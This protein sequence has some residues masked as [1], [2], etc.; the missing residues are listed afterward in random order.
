MSKVL[1]LRI[2]Q[3]VEP[4]QDHTLFDK[5]EDKD[6][7]PVV[8]FPPGTIR[9][10]FRS[11]ELGTGSEEWALPADPTLINVPLYGEQVLVYSAIDGQA[12]SLFQ[13]RYYY[14]C[15]VNAHGTVNNTIMPFIQE[16]QVSGRGYSADGISK[17]SPGSEPK[18][19]SFEKKDILPI[20]PFQGDTIRASRFGSVLRFGST[21]VKDLDKYKEKPFWGQDGTAGDPFI[22]LTCEVKGLTDGYSGDP[23][24][25][26]Y[27]PYY[28]IEKPD[29]DKSFIYLT[30]KQKIKD[31][32]L[33]QPKMGQTPEEPKKLIGFEESQVIIGSERLIFNAR[34][35]EIIMLSSKDIK[36]CTPAWQ[37]D[38][39]HYFTQIS[40]WLKVCVDL[41]E[42]IERY[43]TPAGP[44]GKSSAL[45][46]LKEIQEE[47]EKMRQ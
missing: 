19:I 3:V 8:Q 47:V 7:D 45:E 1:A 6:K 16:S 31:F 27:D 42:G 40:E 13:Q 23:A 43:A 44:T 2:C 37:I 32:E 34:K 26:T 30:S 17:V 12:E 9:V 25:G 20:Q 35:E 5:F 11:K 33:A 18:Q 39:D 41:A 22:S 21:H 10:R 28:K 15:L 46:R 14:L 4:E 29:D 36:F 38:G 24:S